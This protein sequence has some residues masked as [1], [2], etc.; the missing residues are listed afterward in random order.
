MRRESRAKSAGGGLEFFEDLANAIK[1]KW[2]ILLEILGLF[3]DG[4]IE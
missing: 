1:S 3:L 2:L 4:L